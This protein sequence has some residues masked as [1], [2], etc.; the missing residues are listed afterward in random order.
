MFKKFK[1]KPMSSMSGTKSIVNVD[2]TIL[3]KLFPKNFYIVFRSYYLKILIFNLNIIP[4]TSVV[5]YYK[6]ENFFTFLPFES[7]PL[8]SSSMWKRRFSKSITVP[9]G[10]LTVSFSISEPTQSGKNLTELKKNILK[11]LF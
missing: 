11:I 5:C 4:K 6:K 7:I 2:F 10:G 8:P 9:W 1:K 3:W